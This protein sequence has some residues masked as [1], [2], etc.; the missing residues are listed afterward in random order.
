LTFGSLTE[1]L[2]STPIETTMGALQKLVDEGKIG[3]ICLSEVKAETIRRAAKVAKISNVEVELS[4]WATDILHNGVASTCAE[5]GIPITA[6]SPLM[7]GA[8]ADQFKSL[9]ELPEDDF[10]R[11]MPKF[12]PDVMEAN[13]KLTDEIG[14][15]AEAKGCTKPQI[16]IAWV[17]TLSGR[18]GMPVII[19]IPGATTEARVLENGKEVM[20]SEKDMQ[21]IEEILKQNK[22]VGDR[23]PPQL[24]AHAEG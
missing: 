20:L 2:L 5:L 3:A 11:T 23:Y 1:L 19:P 8:L 18:N 10:R 6:Y 12:Q 21:E 14:K 4:L 13:R 17:R 24:M 22:I 7:R 9:D 15:L 16:A